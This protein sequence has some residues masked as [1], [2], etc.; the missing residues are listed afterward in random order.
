MSLLLSQ[1]FIYFR[2]QYRKM[3]YNY[4]L[5]VSS[6]MCLFKMIFTDS[7]ISHTFHLIIWFACSNCLA[8]HSCFHFMI[9]FSH[10]LLLQ[11]QYL[12]LFFSSS[13]FLYS[14]IVILI[15]VFFPVHCLPYPLPHFLNSVTFKLISY[16]ALIT[17]SYTYLLFHILYL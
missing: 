7:S 12:L 2:K 9:K 8:C 16:T 4:Y 10:V 13:L 3:S 17:L 1:N 5:H 11:L 6:F 15:S 14:V